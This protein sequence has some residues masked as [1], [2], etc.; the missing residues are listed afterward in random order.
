MITRWN[1]Y[2]WSGMERSFEQMHE[3]Q[4]QMDRI[5]DGFGAMSPRQGTTWP[6]TQLSDS[7]SELHVRLEVPGFR[8]EDLNVELEAET[9][10]VRGER[11]AQVPE[12]Y[13]L[14]RQER[15]G[16]QFARSFTLPSRVDPEKVNAKLRD[17]VLELS[18]AKIPEQQPRQIRIAE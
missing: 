9:L 14:H 7:G 12:G 15:T 8:Q 16:F 10:T 1:D 18:L 17:G 5:F 11:K 2:G 4:R 13:A 3:L 6:R